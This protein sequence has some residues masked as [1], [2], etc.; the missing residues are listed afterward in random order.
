[1]DKAIFTSAEGCAYASDLSQ[2]SQYIFKGAGTCLHFVPY[3][4]LALYSKEGAWVPNLHDYLRLRLR[5]GNRRRADM[6]SDHGNETLFGWCTQRQRIGPWG[7]NSRILEKLRPKMT[8][9]PEMIP[10]VTG[11]LYLFQ[12]LENSQRCPVIPWVFT[13][14]LVDVT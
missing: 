3:S 8:V 9:W 14:V 11:C 10:P 13:I 6:I 1:M 5:G 12:R 7:K 2:A 4:A